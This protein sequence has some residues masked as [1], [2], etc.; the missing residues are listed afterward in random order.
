MAAIRAKDTKPE[1]AL[2]AAL[3]QV[4]VTGY[5]LHR[6][7]IPG[8]PDLAFIRWKVAVFVDGVFWHGHPDHWNPEKAASDYWRQKIER[9]IRR[10]READAALEEQG[11]TVVRMWDMDVRD[12]L[13]GCTEEVLT[14]LRSSGRPEPVKVTNG[15]AESDA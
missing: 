11:W 10:D 7:D 13:P 12:D 8:R 4:G 6:K 15:V 5:R 2:R 3:R 14:A 9:N 1:L